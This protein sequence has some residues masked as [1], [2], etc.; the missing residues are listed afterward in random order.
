MNKK[1]STLYHYCSLETFYNIMKNRSIWL[2]DVNKSNDSRELAWATEQCK[3]AVINKFLEYSDR[4]KS[5]NDF[6]HTRFRDFN[7]ITD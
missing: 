6:I 2:S 7:R 5:N 1:V 3:I 4:M